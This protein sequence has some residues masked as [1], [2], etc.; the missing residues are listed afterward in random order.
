MKIKGP[1]KKLQQQL[2]WVRKIKRSGFQRNEKISQKT[3]AD[4][5]DNTTKRNKSKD[6]G[7]RKD[8]PKIPDR[9]KQYKQ[10]WTFQISKE[11]STYKL[12]EMTQRQISNWMRK[13]QD[14]VGVKCGNSKNISEILNGQIM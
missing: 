2:K 5:F 7:E 12:V 10:N 6:I 8:T 1:I 11:N 13:K 14:S 3:N 9:V 4:K